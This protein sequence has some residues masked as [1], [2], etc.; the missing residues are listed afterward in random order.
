M[1]IKKR[2]LTFTGVICL[3]TL[4]YSAFAAEMTVY[5]SAYCGCCT[6]WMEQ[7]EDAGFDV[8]A[9]NTEEMHVIKAKFSVPQNLQSCHTAV[10][11][12]YVVEG[13]VPVNDINKMLS[14]TSKI[15]GIATP[16]MPQ[17]A[18][19]MD[20]PGANDKYQVIAFNKVGMQ[21]VQS[22]YND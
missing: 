2:L 6:K 16:G 8:K 19:G 22:T 7:M 15:K 12:G 3:T 13:H 17:S 18:P 11:N 9:I 4:S 5:K 21:Y 1:N 14:A 10:V 20:M